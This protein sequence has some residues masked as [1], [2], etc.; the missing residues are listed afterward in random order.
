M[1][2]QKL[3]IC[4]ELVKTAVLFVSTV[5]ESVEEAF[6]KPPPALPAAHDGRR[7]SYADV[8]IPLVGFM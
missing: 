2:S 3:E 4:I 6:R 7:N 1:V 8:P 5:A